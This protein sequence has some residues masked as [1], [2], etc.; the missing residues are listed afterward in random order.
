MHGFDILHGAI[1]V[2]ALYRLVYYAVTHS[3]HCFS[4]VF[5]AYV[6][7][8]SAASKLHRLKRLYVVG[9]HGI[10]QVW[11]VATC[12]SA[13]ITLAQQR[14]LLYL[15]LGSIE[16]GLRYDSACIVG[17]LQVARHKGVDR[18][19]CHLSGYSL[20]LLYT[21]QGQT[22]WCLTLHYSVYIVHGLAVTDKQ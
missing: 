4:C 22:T 8:K 17:T 12:K 13:P 19:R 6:V 14:G 1:V 5:L 2:H 20:S 16:M 7:K 15:R 9:P 11:Y 18:C 3:Q 10:L 21:M